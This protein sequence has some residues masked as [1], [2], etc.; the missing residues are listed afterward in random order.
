MLADILVKGI[1]QG[2]G[3]RPFVYRL[4]IENGLLGFVQNRGDAGV[5]ITVEGQRPDIERFITQ[6]KT[7][8]PPLCEIHGLT[9][10]Y[11]DG[12]EGFSTFEIK[13][14]SRGGSE[15]GSTIPPDISICSQCLGEMLDPKNVRYRYFFITCT[16]CGPRYTIIR[17]LPY[18]RANTSMLPF[19]MCSN[20]ERE[21][22]FPDDRRFHA[23]TNA[24][25]GCGPRLF[26][27][28]N[29]GKPVDCGDPT[30]KAGQLLDEGCVLAVKG[31]G[32][33]H[34]V[35][36]TTNPE[37]LS[38]LRRVKTR[39]TKPFAIMARNLQTVRS[40]AEVNVL[41]AELL[42]SYSKP[43][44]LLKK[45]KRYFLSELV[46]PSLHTVG[47]MLP[48]SGL[49]HLLFDSTREPALVMTSANQPN[50]P[51]IIEDD[52]A[53]KMLGGIVDYF[54]LHN[55]VIEQRCDDTVLRVV[56]GKRTFIRRSRGFA[57]APIHLKVQSTKDALALG[58][59]LNATCCI[60]TSGR[61][62]ISQH[63]GDV[64]TPETLQFLGQAA[65]HLLGLTKA[66]P[67]CVAC[68][69]HPRFSTTFLAKQLGDRWGIP[70][71]RVQH[72]HAHLSKLM[73]EHGVGEAVGIVCDGYGYGSDGGAWGGEVLYSDME[74]FKRLG[75]LQEQPMAGGDLATRYPLRMV[76]GILHG[77]V[78]TA[79]L[80]LKR[81][82]HIPH[83]TAEVEVMMK[84]LKSGRVPVTS[85]CG[86]ILDAVSALLGI[87]YERTY[88]GEPAMKL[89]A[90]AARGRD[91]LRLDVK[92]NRGVVDTGN[93]LEELYEN[94]GRVS[95]QDLAFSAQSYLARSLGELAVEAAQSED[96]SV[97][98][99]TGG[100]A[101]NEHI[102][103]TIRSVVEE[104]GFAFLAHDKVPPGDGGISLGQAVVAA[105]KT[106]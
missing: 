16:D 106:S 89:E 88:E 14:S 8:K 58:A 94:L 29:V 85:S 37:P 90:L 18:D 27:T 83:G 86:R 80:L 25:P 30:V 82:Q 64:E 24:C 52:V 95:M 91:I 28:D 55:R 65:Q 10:T 96:V 93:L 4:A 6:L 69:L 103:N 81:S 99:F 48:Y 33:F 84:Q 9:V 63:I 15:K 92:V 77:R 41:E 1:V 50:E 7:R 68:D 105:Q 61:A 102:S 98:G 45:S 53:R 40:F 31:N 49:H 12:A 46:S 26:L 22:Y 70:T 39:K 59:E 79:S 73:A 47:V 5:R 71:V 20:C 17:R 34:L 38:R 13:E 35:C 74:S 67:G 56:G 2:V 76:A 19:K 66:Q 87:C 3:F 44:V 57:P 100:V 72:H 60:L 11:R 32:G 23:Q 78:D 51:I 36:S 101:C 97:I 75:H 54:L 42:E 43:I 104:R 21:Y 62:Y